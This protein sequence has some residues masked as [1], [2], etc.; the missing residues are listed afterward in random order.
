MPAFVYPSLL[1]GL[2]IVAVPVLIHLINM[3]RHRRVRWAAMDFLLASQKKNRFWVLLKQLLLLLLR[4]GIVAAV[5]A[6]MAQPLLR[7]DLAGLLGRSK[8]HHVVLLDDSFS[9]SDRWADTS[10]F[11]QAKKTVQAV[12]AAATRRSEEQ[13]FTLLRFSRTALAD[14]PGGAKPDFM[15]ENVDTQFD[16]RVAKA[17]E[18]LIPSQTAAGP[19]KAIAALK[20]LLGESDDEL[21]VIYLVSDFRR[22]NWND[23]SELRSRL[24]E[25]SAQGVELRLI[26]CVETARPNLAVCD[27]RP[28][29]GARAAGVPLFMNVT[30]ANYGDQPARNVSVQLQEDGRN[31]AAVR[32]AEIPPYKTAVQRFEAAFPTAGD[33]RLTARLADDAVAA[34]NARYALVNLPAEVPVLLLDGGEEMLDAWYLSA[35][36]APGGSARTGISPRIDSLRRISA[37]SLAQF[38]AVYLADPGLLEPAAVAAL[39]T[40]VAQGGGLAVFLG[41]R[42]RAV[43]ANKEFYRDGKGFLPLP[44]D[45]PA[46][47]PADNLAGQPDLEVS[48]HPLFE[49][50][51]GTRNSFLPLVAVNRYFPAA[52]E[53]KP[54]ADSGIKVIARLRNGDPLAVESRLGKGRIVVFLTTAAPTWNNWARN[55]PSFV[56]VVQELQSYIARRPQDDR[57]RLV[58]APLT[59]EFSTDRYVSNVRFITPPENVIDN[60]DQKK[61]AAAGLPDSAAGIIVAAAPE[62]DGVWRA[63]FPHAD[64]GGFYE[65][66]L[67][68][69]DGGLESRP[70]AVNVDHAEGDLQTLTAAELADHLS[71]LNYRFF[72]AADL[73]LEEQETAGRNLGDFLLCLA[74]LMLAAEQ[75]LAYSASY[76]PPRRRGTAPELTLTAAPGQG[77][78]P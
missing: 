9:M 52:K 54:P 23:A 68:N 36:L 12:A 7:G 42:T 66:Q 20:N 75:L 44:L 49:I 40:Y 29:G 56:V 65:A 72:N 38:D 21:R 78:S 63:S 45:A 2:L 57:S 4:M 55:N 11:E 47:L 74:A 25:L 18:P 61:G 30:V 64:R 69:I 3:M 71:G 8:T 51:Q 28:A 17:L 19:L 43:T 34:D 32:I 39:E 24:E 10:A 16:R 1:W 22:R 46:D 41:K 14:A 70:F 27:L 35:A 59:L 77:G 76:H 37:D 33:H 15:E 48:A 31:R 13:T 62:K 26:D 60:S 6:A 50:F 58:G 67:T 53:W 73:R 5:V